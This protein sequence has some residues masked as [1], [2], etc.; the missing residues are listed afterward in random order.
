MSAQVIF[1][2]LSQKFLDSKDKVPDQAR[3]VMYYS[4]AIGHHVGVIDC[5][6]QVLICPQADFQR[7]I[8]QLA[9]GEAKRKMSGLLKFGEIVIDSSHTQTLGRAFGALSGEQ[10]AYPDWSKT[11]LAYLRAIEQETALYL[12]VKRVDD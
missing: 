12:M 8:G 10:D 5:L 4:L 11:L 3:Q 2:A 9:E 6:K 7:W 1:Y